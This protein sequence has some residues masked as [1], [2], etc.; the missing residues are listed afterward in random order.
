MVTRASI[1]AICRGAVL[2][3]RSLTID[4]SLNTALDE[5]IPPTPAVISRI[6]RISYG[7]SFF[8]A[9][10]SEIHNELDKRFDVPSK[11][12]VA[13]DLMHWYVRIVSRI[14]PKPSVSY[15]IA[16]TRSGHRCSRGGKTLVHL[17][18]SSSISS[19]GEPNFRDNL[20]MLV[21][22]PP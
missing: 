2:K 10:D 1:T 19:T 6:P 20:E 5:R 16:N 15:K 3:A 12:H 4:P 11:R 13:S 21:C 22:R 8:E 14:C 9:F 18:T 7:I 17:Q